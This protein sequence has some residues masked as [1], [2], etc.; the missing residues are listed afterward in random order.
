MW[1]MGLRKISFKGLSIEILNEGKGFRLDEFRKLSPFSKNP[2][3]QKNHVTHITLCSNRLRSDIR[4]PGRPGVNGKSESV[5]HLML[6]SMACRLDPLS[7]A[8][9][10]NSYSIRNR[11]EWE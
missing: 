7:V 10:S 1:K 8:L 4:Y 5:L 9:F 6:K 11:P 2:A 3:D